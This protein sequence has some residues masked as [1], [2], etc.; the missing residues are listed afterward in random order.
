MPRVRGATEEALLCFM[1]PASPVNQIIFRVLTFFLLA[2]ALA[3][4]QVLACIILLVRHG[5]VIEDSGEMV[6]A[7]ASG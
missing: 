7:T 6:F 2:D 4:V 1:L 5:N 3:Y